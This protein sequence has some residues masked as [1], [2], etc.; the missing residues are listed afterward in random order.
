MWRILAQQIKH[1]AGLERREFRAGQ[2][3]RRVTVLI[4]MAH[5]RFPIPLV[6]VFDGGFHVE[7]LPGR[8]L[9]G[10]DELVCNP[11]CAMQ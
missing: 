6:Q 4:S 1:A 3:P 7:I 11:A 2:S 9:A 8:L 5:D 10:N